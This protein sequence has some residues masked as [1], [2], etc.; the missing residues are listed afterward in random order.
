MKIKNIELYTLSVPL[1]KPFKTALRT[2]NHLEDLVVKVITDTEHTGYGEA[3]PTAVITGDT[4]P[5][6]AGA[7]R[8]FIAPRL[9]GMDISN[10]EG[11]MDAIQTSMVHN[12][13]AKAAVDM[14][15]YDL[16]GKLYGAPLYKLLGGCRQ[17]F[18]TDITISV[19]DPGAMVRDSIQAVEEGFHI[20]KVKVG[21]DFSRDFERISEIRKAV[22]P[23]TK[24]RVDANQGWTPKEAVRIIRAMED[25]ALDIE[26]VEQPVPARDIDGLKFVTD[27]VLTDILADEAVFSVRDAVDIIKMRAA[28]LINIKLMKTGGI[29]NALQICALA[30]AYGVGCMTGCMLESNIAVTAAAHFAAAK[31]NV[32]L[33]DLDGPSLCQYDP[34]SG[35]AQ[36]SGSE[37]RLGDAPG[38]GIAS[39]SGLTALG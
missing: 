26:L 11:I 27:N 29:Y 14:A 2:V 13:S 38:L 39:V 31:K 20:L 1:K 18:D 19:N 30:Q 10:L 33:A 6:A 34:V 7:V 25:K 4:I 9:I 23:Q 3:P 32:L 36:F 37:I 28:D 15:V 16:W 35:G 12:T 22:P 17:S 5:S 8:Q 21:S 24:I